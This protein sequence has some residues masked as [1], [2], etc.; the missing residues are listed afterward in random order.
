MDIYNIH[1]YLSRLSVAIINKPAVSEKGDALFAI[2]D[3]GRND[4]VAK[5]I[6]DNLV[7][8]LQKEELHQHTSS[9][10][11]KYTILTAHR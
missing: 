5:A 9:D 8:T 2:V 11:M 3:G 6:A 1:V 4:E 7:Q 10:Y